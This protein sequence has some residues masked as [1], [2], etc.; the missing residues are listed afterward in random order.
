[1]PP[2]LPGGW[3]KLPN[4]SGHQGA[5]R[6]RRRQQ[7]EGASALEGTGKDWQRPGLLHTAR[8]PFPALDSKA[9]SDG[10]LPA[11][12]CFLSL[13][14]P[15]ILQHVVPQNGDHFGESLHCRPDVYSNDVLRDTDRSSRSVTHK[16]CG[17]PSRT[18]CCLPHIV[19]LPDFSRIVFLA[20]FSGCIL[21]SKPTDCKRL[22][23]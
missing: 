14:H 18:S 12:H 22:C 5:E 6:G 11:F 1:M 20:V 23:V 9:S 7:A 13:P 19:K 8:A 4:A 21:A 2:F 10:E 17:T 3:G 16:L 15:H